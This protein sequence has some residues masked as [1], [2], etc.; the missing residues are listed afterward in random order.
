[1]DVGVVGAAIGT[2]AVEGLAVFCVEP[3]ESL[4]VCNKAK[5]FSPQAT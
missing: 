2:S 1:M 4:V 5:S 3:V